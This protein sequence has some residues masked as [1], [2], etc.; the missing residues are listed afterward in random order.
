MD[1]VLHALVE[2]DVRALEALAAEAAGDAARRGL[3]YAEGA[4]VPY[5]TR[6]T[7]AVST[8][9]EALLTAKEELLQRAAAHVDDVKTH[10]QD[11]KELKTDVI[12]RMDETLRQKDA[13]FATLQQMMQAKDELHRQ[14][15]ALKDETLQQKDEVARQLALRILS[16]SD[17]LDA[18]RER[19]ERGGKVET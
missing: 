13:T 5:R 6:A 15:L 2:G 10:L 14:A 17:Q 12:Q 18:M 19:L 1:A 4:M 11:V 8:H 7:S 16:M 3:D 9:V